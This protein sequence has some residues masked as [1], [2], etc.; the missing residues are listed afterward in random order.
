MTDK[1]FT[2]AAISLRQTVMAR[3]RAFPLDSADV[4]DIAQ[5]TL[6]KLWALRGDIPSADRACRLSTVIARH[7]AIDLLRSRHT[8]PLAEMADGKK[9]QN[10]ASPH[11]DM[12]DKEN[13]EWLERQLAKLP[14][15]ELHVLN[16]RRIERKSNKEIADILGITPHG[17]ATLLSRAR[18]KMM[19][20]VRKK[21]GIS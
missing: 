16:M 9:P 19:E 10:D 5:D 7:L 17:V 21:L 14:P 6:L 13:D 1:E 3:A 15:A 12:V 18:S 8:V 2:D 20:A 4:E 11:S